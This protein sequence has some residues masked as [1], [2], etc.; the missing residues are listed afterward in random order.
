MEIL[1]KNEERRIIPR[2][3]SFQLAATTG[4]LDSINSNRDIFRINYK[5]LLKEQEEAWKKSRTLVHAADL[6]S[7]AFVLGVENEYKDVADYI[8]YE[9]SIFDMPIVNL[10]KKVLG[11]E[12]P[13]ELLTTENDQR[14]KT[15]FD[16]STLK[17]SLH[18]E[19]KNPI[20]W[21]EIGRLYSSLGQTEKANKAIETA[22]YLDPNNRFIIRSASRYYH[23]FSDEKD[24]ALAIIRKSDQLNNDPWLISADIAYST[25][26]GRF[27]KLAKVGENYIKNRSNDSNSITELASA[28]GTLEFNNG[29]VKEA[30]KYFNQSL[31]LP[32]DNSLAQATWMS[33]NMRGINIEESKFA[34]PLAFEANTFN[35]YNIGNYNYA[36]N[37]AMKWHIDEPYSTRPI[38][39]ASYIASIF[40]NDYKI[41]IA[42]VRKGIAIAPHDILLTNNL[43]YFLVKYNQLPEGE[44]IFNETI[45][46]IVNNPES[47]TKREAIIC[48]CWID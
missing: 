20:A 18:N 10:S 1:F 19:P 42:L 25:I 44:K 15:H 12:V 21:M 27:S 30:R 8:L 17:Y 43:I 5:S 47:Y 33:D 28:L 13:E 26:L 48:T 7:S 6:L 16:I 37:E 36:F 22:L 41:S 4:E 46:K 3:R 14:L 23:H 32:N 24:K 38:K 31:I 45:N 34:L 40:L 29:K 39:A 2:L 9:G 11:I 35:Y